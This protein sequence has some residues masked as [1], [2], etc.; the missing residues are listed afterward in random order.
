MS[1]S[2]LHASFDALIAALIFAAFFCL[3]LSARSDWVDRLLVR[4][5]EGRYQRA[6]TT[7]L[8]T[9]TGVIAISGDD[10]RFAEAGRLARLYPNLRILI[11]ESTDIAG[12]LL[13]LGGGIE[14]SRV[15]LETKSRN[16]YEN[17]IFGSS[18]VA[19][20][21]ED[22]WLLVT[23]ALHMPRAVASFEKAG[24]HVEPWPLHDGAAAGVAML[25]PALHEW[26]GLLA[27]R[28]LGRTS[29]LFPM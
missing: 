2:L 12:A 20:K 18:I 6:A 11:S 14:P 26:L 10:R 5:L 27:Y 9:M 4:P 24:F 8:D 23:G 16:T 28:L 3:F 22:R 17:A 15:I 21:P 7:S 19:P 13:K 1:R 25:S 29:Q